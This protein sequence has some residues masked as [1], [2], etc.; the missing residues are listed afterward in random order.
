MDLYLTSTADR[1][2]HWISYSSFSSRFL[3]NQVRFLHQ[4]DFTL[5]RYLTDEGRMGYSELTTRRR[6]VRDGD[7]G[8][9]NLK[10]AGRRQKDSG[11]SGV[12]SPN[13]ATGGRS[14]K[15]RW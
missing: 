2:N 10:P 3:P 7:V 11:V 5:F 13:S 14:H 6:H 9:K 1:A 4:L 15:A 12:S 8:D